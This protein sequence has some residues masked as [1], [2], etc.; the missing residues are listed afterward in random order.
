[1]ESLVQGLVP[2]LTAPRKGDT[3]LGVLL[4]S[5]CP[6]PCPCGAAQEA[7]GKNTAQRDLGSPPCSPHGQR[8]REKAASV[9]AGSEAGPAHPPPPRITLLMYNP[10]R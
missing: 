5:P 3:E 10:S 9:G 4:P 6:A 8:D 7:E 2:S 1:M